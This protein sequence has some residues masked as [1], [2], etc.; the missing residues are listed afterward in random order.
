MAA[1]IGGRFDVEMLSNATGTP[2]Q[3]LI[4]H[5]RPSVEAGLLVPSSTAARRISMAASAPGDIVFAV[6]ADSETY[7]IHADAGQLEQ[8]VLNLVVNARDA[9][10]EGGQISLDCSNVSVTSERSLAGSRLKP[11]L[12]CRITV[13]DTGEGMTRESIKRIFEPFFTTKP[14]GMGTGL[15]LATVQGIVTAMNAHITVESEPGHGST[16]EVYI[17]A[18]D[19][20]PLEV[21]PADQETLDGERS[22]PAVV[23]VCEDDKMVRALVC[24]FLESSDYQVLTAE[25]GAHALEVADEFAAGIDL[26]VTDVIMPVMNGKELVDKMSLLYPNLGVIFLSGYA[27]DVV[28]AGVLEVAGRALIQKPLSRSTLLLRVREI[29]ARS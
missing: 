6:T 3:E 19:A 15:G 14:T 13:T 20:L 4:S 9:M 21:A 16:F 10:P 17:P 7:A 23:L 25:N 12:Y 26:L 1:C 8:I 11:G 24:R 18:H 2:W 22:S 5:L 28:D 27:A 29:L